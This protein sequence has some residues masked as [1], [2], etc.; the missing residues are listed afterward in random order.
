MIS[1]EE[2]E[3]LVDYDWDEETDGPING[4]PSSCVIPDS[5][6][7]FNGPVQDVPTARGSTVV[8][9]MGLT[10]PSKDAASDEGL[11]DLVLPGSSEASAGD[12]MVVEPLH[13]RGLKS[14]PTNR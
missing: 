10:S 5:N 1:Q 4:Y 14:S 12:V 8:T 13:E 7:L 6:L 11:L 2:D 3:V 9:S